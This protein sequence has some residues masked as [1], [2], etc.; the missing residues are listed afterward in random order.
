MVLEKRLIIVGLTL[1][2]GANAGAQTVHRKSSA[3]YMRAPSVPRQIS[4]DLATGVYTRGPS[5]HDRG[6]T[7]VADF[8]NDDLIGPGGGPGWIGT[9]T[10]GG[11]CSW[12]CMAAKGTGLHQSSNASDLMSSIL[13]YYCSSALDTRS[14]GLG[15][16]IT[17]GFYEGYTVFG[18]APTTTA[19]VVALTGM[20]ASSAAGPFS[21]GCYGLI[22]NFNP[23]LPFSDGSFI[24]YSWNFTDAGVGGFGATNPFLACVVS[25]QGLSI[26]TNPTF[27]GAGTATGLGEDG[28]GMVDIIDQLCAVGPSAGSVNSFSFGTGVG[29]GTHTSIAMT[30]TE[31]ADLATTN[32]SYNAVT[33][34][35][36]DTLTGTNAALGTRWTLTLTRAVPSVAG[37]MTVNVRRNKGGPNGLNPTP[38]VTGRVLIAGPFLASLPGAHNGISGEVGQDIP[39]DIAFCGVHFAAQARVSGGGI[40]LSSGVEGTVGTF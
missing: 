16:S 24:G 19:A 28:Q 32:V 4:L 11:A 1:I 6:G 27:G 25:C 39:L 33:T 7:T 13:F 36:A 14:G 26:F 29:F 31:A 34:P 10:G 12:F 15:G 20:P 9:D 3:L 18:G 17:L 35:N 37:L 21:A 30:I 40:K 8:I 22:V 2:L 38:P 23:L 5:T